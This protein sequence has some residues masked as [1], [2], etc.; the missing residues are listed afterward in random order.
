MRKYVDSEN[1]ELSV[2]RC[3]AGLYIVKN[4]GILQNA[5]ANKYVAQSFLDSWAIKRR[6]QPVEDLDVDMY[7][8]KPDEHVCRGCI[9]FKNGRCQRV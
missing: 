1:I 2:K 9:A 4:L 7:N 6:M 8:E 5:T 3:P